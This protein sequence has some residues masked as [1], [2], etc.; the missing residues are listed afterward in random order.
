MMEIKVTKSDRPVCYDDS[1]LGF[2]KVFSN[3]MFV[4]DYERG[5]GW[6]DPQILP[7]SDLSTSPAMMA[8]H[9]GQ[10]I[11]EGMKAYRTESGD[12][13][14]FRPMENIKRF[15]ISAERMC[16][17]TI[18]EDLFLSALE[19][20]ISIDADFVPRAANTSLYIR[21]FAFATTPELGVRP[22]DNYKFVIIT[23]PSGAYYKS[24]LAPVKIYVEPEYIRASVGGV[25]HVKTAGNYAASLKAQQ[26]AAGKGYSQVLWLDSKNHENIEEVGAMN[27]FF[28]IDGEIVTP[29]P[30]GSILEGITRKSCIEILRDKGYKVTEKVLSL[31]EVLEAHAAGKLNEAFG[32]GTAA[33]ISPIGELYFK[34]KK[35]EINNNQI[36]AVSQFIYSTLTDIQFGRMPD[37]YGWVYKLREEL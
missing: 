31:A 14:L 12:L 32:T 27:V 4:M 17:P 11:F 9:Y 26:L 13:Q 30:Q 7:Y 20:L 3:H 16:I 10:S 15:N 18:D 28:V 37:E 29:I 35:Y 34:D 19:K 21:P 25:G 8:L 5:K 2:G 24:G 1:D 36:G 6:H 33:V 23:S 22:A